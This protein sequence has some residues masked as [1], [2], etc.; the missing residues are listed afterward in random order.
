M[1][2]SSVNNSSCLNPVRCFGWLKE[3]LKACVFLSRSV[4]VQPLSEQN[5]IPRGPIALPYSIPK[6]FDKS[7]IIEAPSECQG[8]KDGSKNPSPIPLA[9]EARDIIPDETGQLVPFKFKDLVI[10]KIKNVKCMVGEGGFGRV[11]T[12][13]MSPKKALVDNQG[14]TRV[15]RIYVIKKG[16]WASWFSNEAKRLKAA[17][18]FV[19]RPWYKRNCVVMHDKGISLDKLISSGDEEG[20][21]DGPRRKLIP[22]RQRQNISKQAVQCLKKIHDKGILHSDIKPG[23][24]AINSR[25]EVSLID[26]GVAAKAKG[27]VNGEKQF[28]LLTV[29]PQYSS[30]EACGKE[31]ATQKMDVWAMGLVM[32]EMEMG[33]V[34]RLV[35]ASKLSEVPLK[36]RGLCMLKPEFRFSLF[37]KL[38]EESYNRVIDKIKKQKRISQECK[39]VLLA[40]LARDPNERPTAEQLLEFPYFRD[41][42]LSEMNHMELG[43]AH[44]DAFKAL[45]EAE[46][47]MEAST[48]AEDCM[49]KDNLDRCQS[50]VKKIQER[51]KAL[52]NQPKKKEDDYWVYFPRQ[53][54]PTFMRGLFG[55]SRL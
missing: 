16:G 4:A 43:V 46:K 12:A 36:Y 26:F 28:K 11:F 45:V 22:S 17:G 44:S 41:K 52:N 6:A 25:G 35:K 29:T 14:R 9:V 21:G 2:I 7:A 5:K 38:D 24:I 47:A 55:G 34:P 1:Q 19:Y 31:T 37:P 39:N 15:S 40:C 30:P 50:R 23:N 18:E 20:G 10:R 13:V 27:E 48:A 54:I 49:L 53:N 42:E 51:M 32:F 33:Y 3:K 8:I